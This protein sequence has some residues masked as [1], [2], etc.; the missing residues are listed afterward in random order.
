M[1]IK[2]KDGTPWVRTEVKTQTEV[3][4]SVNVTS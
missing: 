2:K 3:L 1:Q 4:V